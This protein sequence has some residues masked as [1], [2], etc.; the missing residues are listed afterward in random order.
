MTQPAIFWGRIALKRSSSSQLQGFS[1]Q[2]RKPLRAHS[3]IRNFLNGKFGSGLRALGVSPTRVE[4]LRRVAGLG[5]AQKRMGR[6]IFYGVARATVRTS[7]A[8]FCAPVMKRFFP[9]LSNRLEYRHRIYLGLATKVSSFFDVP[10][11]QKP[12]GEKPSGL[13]RNARRIQHRLLALMQDGSNAT[14][15]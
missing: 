6:I 3:A 4:R 13:T 12:A 1:S 15:L 11:G 8:K 7:A 5:S 9:A 2:L 14:K 10:N